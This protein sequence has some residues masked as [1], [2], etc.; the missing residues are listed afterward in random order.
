MFFRLKII[1]GL[2]FPVV[3]GWVGIINYDALAEI[4][5]KRDCGVFFSKHLHLSPIILSQIQNQGSAFD[6]ASDFFKLSGKKVVSLKT[7]KRVSSFIDQKDLVTRI[8]PPAQSVVSIKIRSRGVLKLDGSSIM[9][10]LSVL[11]RSQVEEERIGIFYKL[12]IEIKNNNRDLFLKTVELIRN[13]ILK[14]FFNIKE[15]QDIISLSDLQKEESD[16]AISYLFK[17]LS[18]LSILQDFLRDII[19][20]ALEEKKIYTW[21]ENCR[22][23]FN[24][25]IYSGMHLMVRLYYDYYYNSELYHMCSGVI[26]SPSII[27][28]A[29]HCIYRSQEITFY[30]NFKPIKAITSIY[31]PKYKGFFKWRDYFEDE[32]PHEFDMGVIVF[33]KGTFLDINIPTLS[34]NSQ[35]FTKKGVILVGYRFTDRLVRVAKSFISQTDNKKTQGVVVEDYKD[36]LGVHGESGSPMFNEQGDIIGILAGKEYPGEDNDKLKNIYS[37]I[38]SNKDFILKIKSLYKDE[39]I[40]IR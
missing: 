40:I 10:Y 29:A 12:L 13:F 21:K 37:K 35:R 18:N 14:D 11:T 16:P 30:K 9:N 34:F 36:F 7:K 26:I 3:A 17:G 6:I 33:P 28:T 1:I 22:I 19:S 4:K 27:L 25:L 31:N 20:E 8:Y 23:S 39:K 32:D 24:D 38:G 15:N 5:P 2:F